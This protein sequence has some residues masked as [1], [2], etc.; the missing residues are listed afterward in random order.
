MKTNVWE[1]FT[2]S[3]HEH[4]RKPGNLY[5]NKLYI[6]DD[7]N[8]EFYDFDYET[9]DL[10]PKVP[11]QIGVAA[12]SIIWKDSLVVVGGFGSFNDRGIQMFNFT[13]QKWTR[14]PDLTSSLLAP[15]IIFIILIFLKSYCF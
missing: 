3:I 14:L 11:Y 15:G 7:I 12:G 8:A 5:N 6:V 9:W 4:N 10:W 1:K 13:S 2:S